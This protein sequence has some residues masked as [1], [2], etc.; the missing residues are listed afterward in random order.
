MRLFFSETQLRHSPQQF[1]AVGR[2][3]APFEV[4]ERAERMA[5]GLRELGLSVEAPD[6][7]GLAP[8]EHVHADH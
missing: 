8:I 3:I 7:Y 1:M 6:D 2:I 4:P 5:A